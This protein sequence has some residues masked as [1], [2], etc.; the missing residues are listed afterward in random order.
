MYS[1]DDR[2]VATLDA[3][4]TNF[5]F[6]A[7][8]GQ[9]A[10]VEPVTLPSNA[11]DLGLCLATL[12]EGF[13][14]V[15]GR[16]GVRPAAISFAFPGPADYPA[17]I[18]GGYLPNFPSFRDGVALGPFLTERFGLPV[19]INNDADLYAYGEAIAGALPDINA[20]LRSAGSDKQYRNLLGYT[21]G[22]GFG[23]GLVSGGRLHRG[24]NSCVETFSLRHPDFPDVIVE[25]GV[26]ARAL[27]RVYGELSGEAGHGLEPYDIYRVARG[28]SP[29][30][31]GAALE[32]FA[33]FGRA[34][35]DAIATAASLLDGLIVIGGGIAGARE[36]IMPSLLGQM[37]GRMR[38]LRGE[39]LDRVQMKVYDLDDA[40]EF[41][42][43][44]AVRTREIAVYGTG[45]TV[46]YDPEKR[47]GITT[48]KIGASTAIA[49]GAYCFAL[50][51]LDGR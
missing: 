29:G 23:F 39:S 2:V 50:A 5:V 35:G 36:F 32:A 1:N 7:M 31:R 6:G 20:R 37:R 12:E 51:S 17:G 24:D 47:I 33:R 16:L 8:Q 34:A 19:F 38:T 46:T 9:R 49:V 18:I 4:G 13:R 42:R 28:E 26:A 21:W 43:F 45:R 15:I 25:E 44:A 48:S 11:H 22:T 30:D 40:Q 27:R 3:G 10:V 14:G 41:S